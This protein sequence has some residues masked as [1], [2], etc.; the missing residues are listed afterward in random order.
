MVNNSELVFDIPQPYADRGVFCMYKE[1]C[2]TP[3]EAI[4]RFRVEQKLVASDRLT[5]LGRLDPMAEGLLLVGVS[6]DKEIRDSMLGLPKVYEVEILC[7]VSTD[8]SDV[9]GIV[10]NFCVEEELN[11]TFLKSDVE[12]A[13]EEI[14][15]V[16]HMPY[17]TFSSKPVNGIPLFEYGKQGIELDEKPEK[18][19][20]I[21][22]IEILKVHQ[23]NWKE[24]IDQICLDVQKVHGDFRQQETVSGW[25]KFGDEVHALS[26]TN[27]GAENVTVVNLRISSSSGAYMRS[28]VDMISAKIGL[29]L[30]VYGIR[31]TKVGDANL[32]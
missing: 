23:R 13:I 3:L 11:K 28:I 5:Y 24:V 27:S 18:E 2:E 1:R 19:I 20:S 25:Q 4:E 15:K 21:S 9:L 17:H 7:G 32:Q 6:I 31:R 26:R 29:R 12:K 30:T 16:T 14:K 10:E 8:T 22:A